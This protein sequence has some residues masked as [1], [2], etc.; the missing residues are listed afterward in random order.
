VQPSKKDDYTLT[1]QT[2]QQEEAQEWCRSTS[3]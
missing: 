3:G 2:P 1:R